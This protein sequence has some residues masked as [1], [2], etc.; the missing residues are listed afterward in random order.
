MKRTRKSFECL[1]QTR[2]ILFKYWALRAG[3]WGRYFFFFLCEATESWIIV[4]DFWKMH[5]FVEGLRWG[6]RLVCFLPHSFLT[7]EPSVSQ[8]ALFPGY[9]IHS[10]LPSQPTSQVFPVHALSLFMKLSFSWQDPVFPLH[11]SNP[12][13]PSPQLKSHCPQAL[14]FILFNL[15]SSEHLLDSH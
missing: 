11:V 2:Y 12:A 10:L 13:C 9:S 1:I 14:N 5:S 7:F 4:A 8:A 3:L 15:T 6:H